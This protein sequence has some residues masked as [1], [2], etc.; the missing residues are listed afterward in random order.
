MD[1]RNGMADL[2][3]IIA[4]KHGIE[5][6]EVN[7]LNDG[8]AFV[9]TL[10]EFIAT[11][12]QSDS[13]PEVQASRA[14]GSIGDDAEFQKCMHSIFDAE[15]RLAKLVGTSDQY[16]AFGQ[17]SEALAELIKFIDALHPVIVSAD[18]KTW[19]Q[20]SWEDGCD[21]AMQPDPKHYTD[22]MQEEIQNLRAAIATTKAA[23]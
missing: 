13:A 6:I 18:I 23:K 9:A 8:S 3:E 20:M 19:Q 4:R 16:D 1:T 11:I 7:G 5:T 14:V 10:A 21:P 12:S 22:N 15:S 17:A 2:F